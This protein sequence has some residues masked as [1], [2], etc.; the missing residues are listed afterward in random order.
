MLL[1]FQGFT[2]APPKEGG[3]FSARLRRLQIVLNPFND[4]FM[5]AFARINFC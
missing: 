3:I 2:K 4:R 5:I 1:F